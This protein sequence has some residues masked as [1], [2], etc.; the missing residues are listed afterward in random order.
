VASQQLAERLL[1]A[2]SLGVIYPSVRRRG[3]TCVSVFRPAL[4]THLRKARTWRFRW[5]GK[6][7]PVIEPAD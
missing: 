1:A 5:R 6:P 3:G 7:V 2:G 4:V